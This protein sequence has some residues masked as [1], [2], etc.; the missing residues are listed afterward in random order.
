MDRA[1]IGSKT[2]QLESECS[3]NLLH[4]D[5]TN[6]CAYRAA[7]PEDTGQ[8]GWLCAQ[9]APVKTNSTVDTTDHFKSER[10]ERISQLH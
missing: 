1:R 10:S 8:N 9:G 7:L 6:L 3:Q 5:R 4:T 2:R